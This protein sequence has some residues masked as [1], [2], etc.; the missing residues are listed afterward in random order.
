MSDIA[1]RWQ[2]PVIDSE[3]LVSQA[4]A[5]VWAR[6]RQRAWGRESGGQLFVD[7]LSPHGLMLAVATPPHPADRAGRTWLELDESRCRQEIESAN[8]KGLRLV[9]YW[10]THPQTIPVIS[11]ADVGSFSRFAA[12]YILDLPSPIAIIVGQSKKP[13]GIKAWSFRGR[14]YVE[15]VWAPPD[16]S[17]RQGCGT[18][19]R[20][21]YGSA[22][23]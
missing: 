7:P 21:S 18:V 15:A 12:R 23:M 19:T 9:G 20:R 5:T 16:E 6:H 10:H 17:E 3:L 2:W 22:S 13:E 4:V 8:A 1:W 14:S 11:P